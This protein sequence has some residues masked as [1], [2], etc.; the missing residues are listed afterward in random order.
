MIVFQS[1]FLDSFLLETIILHILFCFSCHMKRLW[2]GNICCAQFFFGA[3]FLRP[4]LVSLIIV[5]ACELCV[6]IQVPFFNPACNYKCL[7]VVACLLHSIGNLSTCVYPPYWWLVL[8]KT[9]GSQSLGWVSTMLALAKVYF[10]KA[11]FC[12]FH[13]FTFC[14]QFAFCGLCLRMQ[15]RLCVSFA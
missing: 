3:T 9:G 6:M 7:Q 13:C 1:A 8:L 5:R 4:I 11:G 15:L 12:F 14:S 2:R 10:F